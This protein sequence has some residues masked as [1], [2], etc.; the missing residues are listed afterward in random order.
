M[1]KELGFTVKLQHENV[2]VATN[3]LRLCRSPLG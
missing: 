3:Q 1:G 2:F